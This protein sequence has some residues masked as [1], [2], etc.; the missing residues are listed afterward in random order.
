M[1]VEQPDD[2]SLF[3]CAH[4]QETFRTF[5]G[6]LISLDTGPA[7]DLEQE[8]M[9]FGPKFE[10]TGVDMYLTRND[11]HEDSHVVGRWFIFVDRYENLTYIPRNALKCVRVK[12]ITN[13]ILW[14]GA[15]HQ[16]VGA[17]GS[18]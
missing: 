18:A 16:L 17:H 14:R 3:C 8:L 6:R 15:T 11:K 1:R 13:S 7:P 12:S 4:R 2:I 10:R 9:S 5:C